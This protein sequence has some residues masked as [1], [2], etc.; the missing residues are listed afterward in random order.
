MKSG[1]YKTLTARSKTVRKQNPVNAGLLHAAHEF[2]AALEAY[3]AADNRFKAACTAFNAAYD[4]EP[5]GRARNALSHRRH[6]NE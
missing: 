5:F 1:A 2:D 3:Q 6:N 4:R